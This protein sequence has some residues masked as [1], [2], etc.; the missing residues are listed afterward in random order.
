MP[1]P[2][3]FDFA[4]SELSQDAFICWLASW[5]D[6]LCWELN[7]PLHETATAFLN[8]LLEVGRGP[9]VSEYQT[10][11]IRQQWNSVDVLLVVNGT[12]AIIIEDKTNSKDHSDQLRRYKKAVVEKFPED[13]IAAVYLK[14]GDQCGF[15]SAQ[16]AGY[17]C[18]LR[19]DFLHVLDRGVAVGVKNDV[20]T[21]FHSYLRRI[22]EAVESF[23]AVLPDKWHRKQ[24]E[25]FFTA[26]RDKL[27]DGD[28]GVRGHG[29]GGSL[30]FRWNQK[31]SRYLRLEGSE[32][33]F[34]LEMLASERADWSNRLIRTACT[35]G[36]SIILGRKSSGNTMT[37][38]VLER[39]YRQ[40]DVQGLLDINQTVETL[41][42]ATALMDAALA[43]G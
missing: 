34:C 23:P 27:G 33:A 39:D 24:W 40:R 1:A 29:G 12:T 4:T 9:K 8:R 15:E 6:P 31:Q 10:I 19:R 11:E 38:A 3:L 22:E 2:N 18:F 42:M 28:W 43:E 21:D 7:G 37:V 14:T 17:G 5:A 16:Q 25:G 35:M 20:F 30:R 26:I 36:V 13:R 32:L 41:R